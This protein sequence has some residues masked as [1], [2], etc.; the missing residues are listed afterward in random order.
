[1]PCSTEYESKI[2]PDEA[3]APMAITQRGS[4][5]CSYTCFTMGAIFLAMVPITISKS[6]W[7]GEKLGRSEPKREMS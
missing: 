5:I 3:Q 1:M 2:P 6:A 7:R 4:A